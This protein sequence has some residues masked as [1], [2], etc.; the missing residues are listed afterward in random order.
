[1]RRTFGV[2]LHFAWKHQTH[3]KDLGYEIHL[4]WLM[5]I[6][7]MITQ[8]IRELTATHVM[9]ATAKLRRS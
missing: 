3:S 6:V 4:R 8:G 9:L 1:M 7:M 2:R 5:E